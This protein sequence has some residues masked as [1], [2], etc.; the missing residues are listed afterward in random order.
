VAQP[1]EIAVPISVLPVLDLPMPKKGG[2]PQ[3]HKLPDMW[4]KPKPVR[5][6]TEK[7]A[8]TADAEKT[9]DAIPTSEV[10]KEDEVAPTPEDEIVENIED[11]P[12]TDEKVEE[13]NLEEEGVADGEEDGDPEVDAMKAR[14]LNQYKGSLIGWFN[15]RFHP[16]DSIPC[17]ERKALKASVVANVSPD[18]FV[19][20]YTIVSPSGNATFDASVKAAMDSSVG[21]AVPPPPT[22]YPEFAQSVV[23]T[24]FLG[25]RGCN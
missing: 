19:T 11:I 22:N 4:A 15:A 8:P 13:E 6:V 5:R 23:S 24:G 17:E 10:A 1:K 3:K 9:P 7:S 21:Q 16:P 12:D 2:K 20:G 18:F 25:S 14:A